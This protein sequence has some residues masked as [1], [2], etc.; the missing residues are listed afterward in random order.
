MEKFID[1]VKGMMQPLIT[2]AAVFVFLNYAL[3]G[4]FEVQHVLYIVGAILF[5][6]FGYTF[7]KNFN[8]NGKNGGI[9]TTGTPPKAS[10][11][12]SAD[13]ADDVPADEQFEVPPM[14]VTKFDEPSFLKRVH[15]LCQQ[16]IGWQDETPSQFFNAAITIYNSPNTVF[17]NVRAHRDAVVTMIKLAEASFRE[18][19][20]LQP[21]ESVP[22]YLK[23]LAE[24][25]T[26]CGVCNKKSS[27]EG[28]KTI[29]IRV[30]HLYGIRAEL[31]SQLA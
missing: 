11:G 5:F 25:P 19:Y 18:L 9:E 16:W 23:K 13:Y 3:S 1:G 12:T 24:A 6:W 21:G 28:R 26:T 2:V 22:E 17:D 29:L 7:V 14:E 15:E 8:F 4:R 20:E 30:Q 27:S 10:S 31:E